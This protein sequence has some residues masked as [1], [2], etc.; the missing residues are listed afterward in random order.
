M[1]I[2]DLIN[3]LALLVALSVL[4]GFIGKRCLHKWRGD[5][6]QG[7]LFGSVAVIGMLHPVFLKPGVFF[8]G[9]SVMLSLC[10]LFFGP[11][12]VG[13]ASFLA[14]ACRVWQGGVGQLMG[15]SVIAVS[16]ALGLAFYARQTRTNTEVTSGLLWCLGL[17]VH[18]AMI[19]LIFL[20]PHDLAFVVLNR[21]ALPVAVVYPLATVL[22]GKVLSDQR[23]RG[24]FL[25][26]LQDN[27]EELRT[28]LYSIGDGIV[29]TDH[30]GRVR[31]LNPEAERLLGWKELEARG[32]PH[33]EVLKIV[34][35]GSHIAVDSPVT[36]VLRDGRTVGLADDE[37]LIARN[38]SIYPIADCCAP[39]RN[40]AGA[41]TGVV[42]VFRDQSSERRS[43]KA[44]QVE[45]DNLREA[46]R[47]LRESEQ[48][49]R[50]LADSGQGM[51]WTSG[52]DKTCDYLNESWLKFTG[53]TLAQETGSGWAESI[54]PDDRGAAV[55]SYEDAFDRRERF[56]LVYRLL[57]HD[58]VYRWIQDSGSPR[59]DTQ[60][61]FLGYIGHCLDITEHR[62]T[63]D[64]LR[65]IEWMLAKKPKKDALELPQELLG[66]ETAT[67]LNRDGPIMKSVGQEMLASIVDEYLDLLGTCSVIFEANGDYAFGLF[68]SGWCRMLDRATRKL[69]GSDDDAAALASGSWLCHESCWTEC[70][71]QVLAKRAA[72]DTECHGGIR[73]YAVPIRVREDVVGVIAF[74]YGDPP[75]DPER[76]RSLAET[77][78]VSSDELAREA[79]AYDSRP[80]YIIEMAKSRLQSSAWLIGSLVE[81]HQSEE[82]RE[83]IEAQFR[84][85]QKM[86]AVGRL[87]GGVAHDFNNILQAIIG[88][89]ELL[90]EKLPEQGEAREF[91]GEIV[92]E[93][94]RAA[95]LTRQL[96]TFA[97]K[98]VIDPKVIDI[99]ESVAVTLK[100]LR[101]LLGE[102]IDLIWNPDKD[103]CFV[104]MD[105]GQLGQ[106]LAN[107]AVNARD[108]IKGV[109]K[110]L[111]KTG[112]EIFD[113]RKC[114]LNPGY[115]PGRYVTLT[116]TDNG[117]G[118]DQAI[119]ERLFEP[120]FTTKERGKGT[121]LGLATVYGTVK[122]NNGHITVHSTPGQ[123][124]VFKIY[125]PEHAAP[126]AATDE[127]PAK[128][129]SVPSGRETVLIVDDEESLLRAGRRM[130]EGL[131]YT[132]LT[133][134]GPEEALRLVKTYPHEIHVLLTDV[135]M[136]G[137]SGRDLW[138]KLEPLRP[139]TK[140]IY[141]S[142]F[143]ANIIAQRSVLD[144]SV[145]FLQKPFTKA[146]LGSKLREVLTSGAVEI[147]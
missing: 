99:N 45:R 2:I 30:E 116:V 145:N 67:A 93:S 147:T 27:R 7:V 70:A 12:A 55:R 96:L 80:P 1:I 6:L 46:M 131:G 126:E 98:Q 103:H 141:M 128:R 85:A 84:Q 33:D 100:M 50:I 48:R 10:G 134:A 86:E 42:M 112:K 47:A 135:V 138:R 17:L 104:K 82:A 28:T 129:E 87:A 108:A 105:A 140:C 19:L 40:E 11:L 13:I 20:L 123:G 77:C 14:I 43:Q 61:N 83:K 127:P 8:D 136:P 125:L 76:L 137:M 79:G 102:D 78:H 143:T 31:Q 71:K 68:E 130:L 69:C 23:A 41:L 57:R 51:I 113:E 4:S 81:A 29:T 115:V 58:G 120:F 18:A 5:V 24:R 144:K 39:I 101:R 97:R 121:G 109:G 44:L 117:C 94:K 22:I 56:S 124:S 92:S 59:Y 118:M 62:Q 133:A 26:E 32:R 75:R 106:I 16:G 89:S 63:E 122:Q 3:N 91:T 37:S 53:K 49:F 95:A 38:G 36:R 132:V 119:L 142:G 88:Y 21:I 110:M 35:E 73:V 60:G 9:R 146:A 54:H 15:I 74:G 64:S 90:L 72:V 65:R 52:L 107:L 25:E 139:T 114:S 111:I 34:K 66:R